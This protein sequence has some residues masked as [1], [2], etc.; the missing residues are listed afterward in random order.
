MG[1]LQHSCICVKKNAEK[2]SFDVKIK[3]IHQTQADAEH[4]WLSSSGRSS[5]DGVRH[6]HRHGDRH[7]WFRVAMAHR[8]TEKEKE[9][10]S[11]SKK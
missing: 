5:N 4:Y 6:F 7:H 9:K 2:E 11:A 10:R 1:S 8:A 3:G